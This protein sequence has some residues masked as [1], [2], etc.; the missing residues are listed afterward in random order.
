MIHSHDQ[1]NTQKG[2]K[3]DLPI[4]MNKILM[5]TH[6]LGKAISKARKDDSTE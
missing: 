6:G 3:K 5:V 2:F 1:K 4:R